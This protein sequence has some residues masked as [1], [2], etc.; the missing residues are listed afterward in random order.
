MLISMEGTIQ[1]LKLKEIQVQKKVTLMRAAKTGM[2]TVAP[3]ESYLSHMAI[4]IP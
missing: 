3:K 1:T 2:T 4:K